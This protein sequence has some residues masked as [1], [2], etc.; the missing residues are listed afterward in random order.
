MII[1]KKTRILI[2]LHLLNFIF[3]LMTVIS[4]GVYKSHLQDSYPLPTFVVVILGLLTLFYLPLAIKNMITKNVQKVFD[5]L[6]LI[7]ILLAIIVA[8]TLYFPCTSSDTSQKCLTGVKP[9]VAGISLQIIILFASL[10][11]S[12]LFGDDDYEDD[13][14]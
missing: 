9:F 5:L 2:L 12:V 13:E 10:G 3:W 1:T 6:Y 7:F 4:Y 11:V 8:N 14:Y